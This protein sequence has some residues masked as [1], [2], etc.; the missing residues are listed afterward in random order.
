[1]QCSTA[2]CFSRRVW[3]CFLVDV[4]LFTEFIYNVLWN[5][6]YI[7]TY[8]APE[9][10]HFHTVILK[11][12]FFNLHLLSGFLGVHGFVL[13]DVV[14]DIFFLL[15]TE[16]LSHYF[17]EISTVADF[18]ADLNHTHTHTRHTFHLKLILLNAVF[19]SSWVFYCCLF[20]FV[21]LYALLIFHSTHLL[22]K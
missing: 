17:I 9:L 2:L 15:F 13:I 14:L 20:F 16:F 19:N 3:F 22:S 7:T 10:N 8:F 21:C 5:Y 4:G 12:I 18:L 1:M 6:P 11:I